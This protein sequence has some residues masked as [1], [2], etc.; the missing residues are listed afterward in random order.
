MEM[1]V[2]DNVPPGRGKGRTRAG[3]ADTLLNASFWGDRGSTTFP[4]RGTLSVSAFFFKIFFYG[5]SR[6]KEVPNSY[7]Y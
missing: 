5:T 7:I 2:K 4:A 3:G 1:A 6:P